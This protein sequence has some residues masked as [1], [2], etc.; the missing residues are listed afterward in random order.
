MDENH[1]LIQMLGRESCISVFDTIIEYPGMAKRWYV[2][3]QECALHTA[4]LRIEELTAQNLI[5]IKKGG[6]HNSKF[7]YPTEKGLKIRKMITKMESL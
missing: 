2:E 4:H 7:L 6:M 1:S 3:K 5:E